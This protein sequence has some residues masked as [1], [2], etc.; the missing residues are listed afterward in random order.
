[1]DYA[2]EVRCFFE[3][4]KKFSSENGKDGADGKD[5]HISTHDLD[6]AQRTTDAAWLFSR[7]GL[8]EISDTANLIDMV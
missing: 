8:T 4:Q 3:Q 5:I 7:E 1:M 6:V 2:R